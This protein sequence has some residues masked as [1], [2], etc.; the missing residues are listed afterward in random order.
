M[1]H[2]AFSED[3]PPPF[4]V[5]S[6]VKLGILEGPAADYSRGF[7]GAMYRNPGET[8]IPMSVLS[9]FSRDRLRI[10][11]PRSETAIAGVPKRVV[12]WDSGLTSQWRVSG[13]C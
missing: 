1:I 12:S 10:A 7:V 8:G 3:C 9:I 4:R 2:A 5:D 11:P 13:P 6:N